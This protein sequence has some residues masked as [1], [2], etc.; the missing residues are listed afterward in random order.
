M[1]NAARFP[2]S[3]FK[4]RSIFDRYHWPASWIILPEAGDTPYVLGFR[5]VVN[6]AE[7]TKAKFYV[8]ADERYELYLDGRLIARGS[9]RGSPDAWYYETLEPEM[10]AGRHVL[11]ARVWAL[12][13]RAPVA[14]FSV[15]PGFLLA[16][17]NYEGDAESVWSTGR[18]PWEVKKL[19]GYDWAEHPKVGF[20]DF[21][22]R[23]LIL[24][25]N[26]YPWGV[27]MGE[28]KDWVRAIVNSAASVAHPTDLTPLR[29]L[30]PGTLPQ[31]LRQTV[32]AGKV[33]FVE[34]LKT[35][36]GVS[37]RPVE[38]KNHLS[39]LTSGLQ[40]MLAGE[41]A[42]K[43][44]VPAGKKYRAIIDLENY[45][46]AY[47]RLT[48]SG[49]RG[50]R[51]SIG[52]AEALFERPP[53]QGQDGE[54]G[55]RNEIESRKF[56][57]LTDTFILDGRAER[58]YSTL[59]WGAGRYL[60]LLIE[61][62]EEDLS[63]D[64]LELEETRYPLEM[65]SSFST[66]DPR[67]GKLTPILL[68]TLQ[69]NAHE[70]FMDC[71]YYEQL[72]YTGDTLIDCLVVYAIT[73]DVRL[74]RKSLQIFDVSRLAEG[75]PQSRF[76]CRLRQFIPPFSLLWISMTHNHALWRGER[77]FIRTLLPGVRAVLDAHLARLTEEGLLAGFRAWNFLDWVPAW[78]AGIPPD[79]DAEQVN[80]A[81]NWQLVY[82]LQAAIELENYAG[83]PEL[84][85]R[86]V[87]VAR[88]LASATEAAFWD[89]GRGM[90]ADDREHKSFSEHAQCLAILSGWARKDRAERSAQ[91]LQSA[92][93]LHR[94][95][96][97]FTHYLFE[98][99]QKLRLAD[100]FYDGLD[101]WFELPDQGFVTVL[102]KPEP[103]R[104]DCHAWGSH[105]L[106]HF[107]STI[108]GIRP[109]VMGFGEVTIAPLLGRL[110]KVAGKMAHPLGWIELELQ[111]DG[112]SLR[113]TV[114][115]PAGVTGTFIGERS[116][117]KLTGGR[118]PIDC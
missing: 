77:E 79:G 68:R 49:G 50:A 13:E 46:C 51:I 111:R 61:T 113:G 94:C 95:T 83:E 96:I 74:V 34:E 114:T 33:R 20:P 52:W 62:G 108:L 63:L 65:E 26:F 7:A 118:Q 32:R 4:S 37:E 102:E 44:V 39:S 24:N 99:F 87:R 19:E 47:P 82:A 109:A 15:R 30:V 58:S 98:T 16:A 90:Y 27:E 112:T 78:D 85:A 75:L 81:F 106:H 93:D 88:G 92:P 55:H 104:S 110:E 41:D 70:T 76:P 1:D 91:G 60:Q 29:L 97:Y 5:L 22:G 8:T 48:V 9:E 86:Y 115:L 35:L 38:S 23:R 101:Y 31:M 43:F 10:A 14:Q 12:G 69:M 18:A 54:K 66:N 67:Y 36:E 59:W 21:T 100:A 11:F 42:V 64:A 105:P 53:S 107:Y 73:H 103:S 56:I 72:N 84:S 45:Y 89:E 25:G 40:G 57:G 116:Q 17:E 80:G 117:Q 28:G 2:F 71:P 6:L 3:G